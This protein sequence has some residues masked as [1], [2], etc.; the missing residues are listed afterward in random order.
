MRIRTKLFTGFILFI[1][2]YAVSVFFYLNT[3]QNS[4]IHTLKNHANYFSS[5][6]KTQINSNILLHRDQLAVLSHTNNIQEFLE[7]ANANF[8]FQTIDNS[9]LPPPSYQSTAEWLKTNFLDY[10]QFQYGSRIFKS[11]ELINRFGSTILST[12]G[13]HSAYGK[14]AKIMEAVQQNGYTIEK[15]NTN[16]KNKK[17]TLWLT[18]QVRGPEGNFIGAISGELDFLILMKEAEIKTQIFDSTIFSVISQSGET[19][20]RSTP[21]ILNEDISTKSYFSLI[22]GKEGVFTD[23]I[24]SIE[25]LYAYNTLGLGAE[26]SEAAWYIT[27]S[28]SLKEALSGVTRATN[29]LYVFLAISLFSAA[30]IILWLYYSIKRPLDELKEAVHRLSNKDLVHRPSIYG[31][32]EISSVLQEFDGMREKLNHFYSNLEDEAKNQRKQRQKA[33]AIAGT[34]E[35]THLFN[36][37]SFF[38]KVDPLLNIFKHSGTGFALFYFDLNG[39]KPINDTHGHAL[40]DMVLKTVSNRLL[41]IIRAD[42][43]LARVGGDEFALVLPAV[44]EDNTAEEAADRIINSISSPM[45]LNGI[46]ISVGVS[47]GVALCPQHGQNTEALISKAD[48][49]MYAAKASLGSDRTTTGSAYRMYSEKDN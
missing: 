39:F 40:G 12:D 26:R 18:S 49:A 15:V 48:K 10:F 44:H 27:L 30:A 47:I 5:Q 21:F 23:T 35:L 2:L 31:R 8:F 14:N 11:V 43:I 46:D 38:S 29:Q 28:Y 17:T 3:L 13:N 9:K 37:R 22:E 33:E 6:I 25:R 4:Y 19:L 32:D 42:D 36:R 7:K 1:G 34:D 16:E 45:H 41:G 24:N 20:Y